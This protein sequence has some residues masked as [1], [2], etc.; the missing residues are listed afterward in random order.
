MLRDA[1]FNAALRGRAVIVFR[2]EADLPARADDVVIAA[3][4]RIGL[5]ADALNTT[6]DRLGAA[7]R[8]GPRAV[9]VPESAHDAKSGSVA[10]ALQR[11]FAQPHPHD[12]H[13]RVIGVGALSILAHRGRYLA[14]FPISRLR[15]AMHCRRYVLSGNCDDAKHKRDQQLR[16]L[17]ELRWLAALEGHEPSSST[18]PNRFR[19]TRWPDFAQLPHDDAHLTLAALLSGQ[20]LTLQSAAHLCDAD[21][22]AV[23]AF[24]AACQACGYLVATEGSD[25]AAARVRGFGPVPAPASR[26]PGLFA[27]LLSALRSS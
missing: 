8:S 5:L 19:L 12:T 10:H 3:P 20:V 25:V 13:V 11:V 4:F 6:F 18:L 24:L 7:I 14:D 27:R 15:E 26:S 2:H 17:V 16:P 22:A 21:P 1:R 23:G 9:K